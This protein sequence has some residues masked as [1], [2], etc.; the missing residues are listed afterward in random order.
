MNQTDHYF[1]WSK[2]FYLTESWLCAYGALDLILIFLL[3][4]L[5][6]RA[7]ICPCHDGHFGSFRCLHDIDD[8]GKQQAVHDF[9]FAF[10]SKHGSISRLLFTILRCE[11]F[12]LNNGHAD[13][14]VRLLAWG[15]LLVFYSNTIALDAL[16]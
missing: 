7:T 14:W 6:W 3:T 15:F 4:N 5:L 16:Y 2:A 11:F 10:I 13:Q 8:D 1:F 12:Y 9:L